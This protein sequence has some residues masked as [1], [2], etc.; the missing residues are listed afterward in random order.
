DD[1]TVPHMIYGR[2][3]RS[4][5]A[6]ARIK[7][8]DVEKAK[9]VKGV[10]AVVTYRDVNPEWRL[11]WPPQKPILDDHLR[12]V[13]DPVAFVAADTV[14]IA[15]AAIELIEVEYEVLSASLNG[16]DASRDDAEQ[17]YP[18]LFEHNEISP[19]FPFFQREN[20]FWHLER[21]NVDEGFEE[22]AYVA[23]DKVE[24]NKMPN[25]M[26]PEPPGAIVRWDGDLN[27]KVWATSQGAFI[28]KL[29]ANF[30]IPDAN[31][32][33]E[34][35]N[36]GGSY[37]NKQSMAMQVMCGVVLS[38]AA[39][40]PVKV[41]LTKTEQLLC[42][43]N[44]LGSQIEAK[45]GMDQEG[46]VR[47]VKGKWVV[48]AGSF[49]NATQGQVGVGLGEAQLIMAKCENW[50]MDS[51]L[52]ATNR[53][54]AGIARG[55]GGME[56]NACLN[57][58]MCRTMEA[59]N[60]DPVEVYKKNYIQ[61]GD[62]FVWRDGINWKAHSMD[63]T[64]AIQ[65]AADKFG[66]KDAWKGW[67]KPTWVSED[68][69]KR[70]GVGVG[71]IGNADA[72]EDNNEAIVRISPDLAGDAAHVIITMDVT[73][74]GM[75]QRAALCKMVAEIL[76]VP[77][78]RVELTSPG[79]GEHN[80]NSFGLCGSRGTV[81]YGRPVCD[82]AEDVRRQLFDLAVPHLLV[83]TSTMELVD[84]G[85]RSKHRP[86]RFVTWKKLLPPELSC[87]GYGKHIETFGS[88]SV[89]IVFI[90]VEVDMET[91]KAD[92]VR[93]LSGSDV[94][95]IIDPAA[96]EMQFHAGIGAS[97]MDSALFEENI[98]DPATGRTMTYN[99]IE[100]KWRPFNQ[101]P[102]F[103][104]SILESQFDTFQFK[105]VGVAEIT[106]AATAPAVMQAIS[107]AIGTHVS[108]YPATPKVVLKA[109]GKLN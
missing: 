15:D 42:F 7:S 1:Y 33:I 58:L 20:L 82:A 91:G 104:T 89:C 19:G 99:M 16:W 59:G 87:V 105:A 72:G 62:R 46:V 90:E 9:R 21:G 24:Y 106:G 41:F 8:I 27:F 40:R 83:P 11:G 74:S 12:Y 51:E 73:E 75:G 43:E 94:G 108:E 48:D 5:H 69:K 18:G 28:C 81:T 22:C 47:A 100:Y 10:H 25:P 102:K 65:A 95:Q 64:A 98:V 66:W 14:E 57:L 4:P 55:Y 23:E 30:A 35:F 101:F 50:D 52:V 93:M 85:V 70:R 78:E 79:T 17:L 103:D 76:N 13:G 36:V 34:T 31:F 2:C 77:Y 26:A 84:F 54:P 63:Y 71:I 38:M 53:T 39:K 29:L 60:F 109:L 80:P 45:I 86:E 96:L 61:D 88:P 37:G 67:G 92:V 49:S 32:K 68:G 44:R 56:L 97:S 6:H 3:L 107:N